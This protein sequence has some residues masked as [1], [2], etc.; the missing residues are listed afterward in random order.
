MVKALFV[1][2]P[3]WLIQL[4]V[5]FSAVNMVKFH[6]LPQTQPLMLLKEMTFKNKWK[7]KWKQL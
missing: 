6:L 4:Y 5:Q 2:N 3:V 1:D 7:K